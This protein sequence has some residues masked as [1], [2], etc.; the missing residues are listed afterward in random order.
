MDI[1]HD[2][3]W[4]VIQGQSVMYSKMLHEGESVEGEKKWRIGR[5]F[6]S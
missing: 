2:P 6:H 5:E 3:G 4:I 1:V